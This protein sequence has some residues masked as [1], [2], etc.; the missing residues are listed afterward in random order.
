VH[1]VDFDKAGEEG[2]VVVEHSVAYS[3]VAG[4]VYSV[5]TI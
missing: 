3:T 5:E 2:L 4:D 1:D